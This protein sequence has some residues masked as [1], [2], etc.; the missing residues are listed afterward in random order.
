MTGLVDGLVV[1][2]AR[3]AANLDAARGL[4][5]SQ[6]VLLELVASGHGR[7]QAYRIVQGNAMKT[8]D[9]GGTLLE[10]LTADPE[11]DLD[12]DALAACFSVERFLGSSGVVFD[13]LAAIAL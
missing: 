12:A 6:A 13:R 1:D 7:D 4:V 9:E 11:C 10:H 3:M 5:F 8:W 2:A